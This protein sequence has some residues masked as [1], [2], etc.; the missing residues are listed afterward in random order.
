MAQ[1]LERAAVDIER[2]VGC[3]SRTTFWILFVIF[4]AIFGVIGWLVY[5]GILVAHPLALTANQKDGLIVILFAV[6]LSVLTAALT[7]DYFRARIF[8]RMRGRR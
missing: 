1:E 4:G 6:L 8:N 3:L 2:P 7:R 5:N